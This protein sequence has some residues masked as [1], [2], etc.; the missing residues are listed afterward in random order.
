MQNL[1]YMVVKRKVVSL[2][3]LVSTRD[4][5]IS[6]TLDSFQHFT[7][8]S[9]INSESCRFLIGWLVNC[10]C[11]F[12]NLRYEFFHSAKSSMFLLRHQ[13]SS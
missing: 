13:K 6:L 1:F 5:L 8:S 2:E 11:Y 7:D 4:K 10:F 9:E 3:S 12:V